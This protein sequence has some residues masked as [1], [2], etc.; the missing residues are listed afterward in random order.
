MNRANT[1]EAIARPEEMEKT[2]DATER[3]HYMD[4]IRALAM[5]LGVVFHAAFAYSP[6][7]HNL[8]FTT[9]SESSWVFDFVAFFTHLF[10]MPVFFLISGFFAIMLIQKRGISGL[11]K[12]RSL[13]ILLPFIIFVPILAIAYMLSIGWAIGNVENLSPMLQ[14]FKMMQANPNAPEPPLSTMHLWF[15]FN[16]FLFVLM[17][18]LMLK[19][20]VLNA[21]WLNKLVTAKF[22]VI[23]FPLLLVP[24]L[25]S[26]FAPHPAPEKF[27][28][29]LWSIGF[30]GLFFLIGAVIFNKQSLLE[31]LA[32]Y[33]NWM[34]FAALAAYGYFYYTLPPTITGEQVMAMIGGFKFEMSHLPIAISEAYIAVYMSFYILIQGKK[35]LN[36]HNHAIKL[37]AD[38]SY[39]VY[40]VHMPI[41]L[42]I[43]F[44]LADIA[45][46]MWLEFLISSILTFVI[47]FLSYLLIVRWTPIGWML[48]GKK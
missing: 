13:R 23:V 24:A 7:M 36:Q 6:L 38:S 22:L 45:L 9:G 17:A 44:V 5:L 42:M 35:F 11:L 4:N 27:Y 10:R 41:L 25:A 1:G 39:W 47:G 48:N 46:N 32:R 26:Q 14:F 43:Q 18:A 12:N 15:L 33:K 2:N 37:I 3:L 16:L 8:W 31:E 34:L 40:L 21:N 28:P 30:Y 29:E 20:K 19:L